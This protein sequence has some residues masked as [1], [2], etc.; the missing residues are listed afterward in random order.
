ME[1]LPIQFA[2]LESEYH[3]A[4]FFTFLMFLIPAPLRRYSSGFPFIVIVIDITSTKVKNG[5]VRSEVRPT[6]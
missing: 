5:I 2:T 3:L 6:K 4:I 1:V